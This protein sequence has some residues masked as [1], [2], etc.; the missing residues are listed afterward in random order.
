MNIEHLTTMV[1]DISH[2]F[3]AE[4][5]HDAAV[6]GIADHLRKFWDPVMRKQILAHLEAG[7]EGLEPLSREAVERLGVMQKSEAAA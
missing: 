2:Y 5:D 4:P 6:Q 3:A 1:N 7:G